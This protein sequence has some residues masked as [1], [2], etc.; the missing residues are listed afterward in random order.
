[1]IFKG[2]EVVERL[3]GAIPKEKITEKLDAHL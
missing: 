3:V 2:G 1:M